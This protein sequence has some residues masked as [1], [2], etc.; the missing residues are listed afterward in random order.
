[1]IRVLA[2][3]EGLR[4]ARMSTAIKV[5]DVLPF[6]ALP[7][8][9]ALRLWVRVYNPRTGKSCRALVLDVGPWNENDHAYVFGGAR[10]AAESGTDSRDRKTNHA[11][12]DLGEF[13]WHALGMTG[14]DLVDWEFL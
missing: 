8:T 4:G 1:M 2:T 10:P 13:V 7:S 14:N 6:V 11:G 5:D 3:R 12:I 9:A